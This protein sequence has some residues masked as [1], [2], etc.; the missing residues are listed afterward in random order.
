LTFSVSLLMAIQIT[1]K[2]SLVEEPFHFN[3]LY[4]SL[5]KL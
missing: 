2:G 5:L 1:K 3:I 4:Q